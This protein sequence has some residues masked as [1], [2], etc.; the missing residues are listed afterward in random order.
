MTIVFAPYIQ[1]VGRIEPYVSADEVKYSA[2]ASAIDFSNLV[3]D[4]SQAAQDR[5]LHQMIVAASAKIDAYCFGRLGTLNATENTESGHDFHLDRQGRFKIHPKYTPV[6]AVTAFSWGVNPAALSPLS[7]ST[8]NVW[9]EEEQIIVLPGNSSTTTYAGP[10]ALGQLAADYASGSFYCQYTYVNGWPNSFTSA[11]SAAAATSISIN[12]ATG[13]F[14]GMY[15]TIWD[16]ANDEYVQVANSYTTGTS[17]PLVSP[18][19][20]RHGSGVNVSAMHP[21]V[22]QACIHFVV[23]MVKQRGEGG[24]VLTEMGGESMVTGKISQSDDDEIMAYD[25]LD[26]FKTIWGRQ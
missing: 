17:I 4:G 1:Q 9:L 26:E 24:V 22:K 15:L 21:N 14:A 5:S 7:L 2:T 11:T 18:L 23:A 13:I 8:A 10:G 6:N 19:V 25:L 16:G 12:D 20:Y 3:E